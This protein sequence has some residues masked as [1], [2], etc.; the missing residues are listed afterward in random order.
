VV[1]RVEGATGGVTTGQHA[2]PLKGLLSRV[3][4]ELAEALEVVRVA[5][6]RQVAFVR[7]LVVCDVRTG[8]HP[9]DE[10]VSAHGLLA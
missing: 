10:A 4:A 2:R 6:Q 1:A 5:E 8:I 7:L 3:V 9:E